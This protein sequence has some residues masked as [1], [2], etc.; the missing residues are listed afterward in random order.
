MKLTQKRIFEI[1]TFIRSKLDSRG[2]AIP[3]PDEASIAAEICNEINIIADESVRDIA[4]Y[5]LKQ[6]KSKKGKSDS[7][8]VAIDSCNFTSSRPEPPVKKRKSLDELT[9]RKQISRRVQLVFD[10]LKQYAEE[11]DIE[12]HRILGLLLTFSRQKAVSDIGESLW[13]NKTVNNPKQVPVDTALTIYNDCSLGRLTYTNMRKIAAASS[14]KV[15]PPWHHLRGKQKTITPAIHMLPNPYVGV[16][17]DLKDA[18]EM[19]VR[20]ILESQ[21]VN[22]KEIPGHAVEME[23]K[24]GFDGN[25]GNSIYNQVN[26]ESTNNIIMTMFCPLSLQDKSGGQLFS[27]SCPNSPMTQRPLC[28]QMGKETVDNLRS[29]EM[30]NEDI[31]VLANEGIQIVIED[32][33]RLQVVSKI[34]GYM[35]D[36]KAAKLYTGLGGSYCDLCCFSKEQCLDRNV[37][38]HGFNI[39]RDI[40]DIMTIF[41]ELVNENGTIITARNDYETR[42]GLTTK[43][44]TTNQ[45]LSEQVLHALL[46][47]FDHWMKTVVHVKAGVFDWSE[48]PTSWNQPFL[49]RAK[50]DIQDTIY[51]NIHGTKWDFP[52]TSGKGGTTTTGNVARDLLHNSSNREIILSGVSDEHSE[53]LSVYGRHLSVI[54][55]ILCSSRCV[56]VEQYKS[57]CTE[58]YLHLLDKFPRVHNKHLRGPWI[59]ITPS[60]HKLL[61][62]SWELILNNNSEGLL[63]LDE[64]GLEGCNKILRRIRTN[65]SRKTSQ[66]NNLSDTIARMWVGSDTVVQCERIKAM[67]FCKLCNAAGHG[68]RYC[69]RQNI[70]DSVLS[71]DEHLF[72]ILTVKDV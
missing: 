56:R 53:I 54:L 37:V 22:P 36:G 7:E 48:S 62:H 57:F 1:I 30:Y 25:G 46:R 42:G 70:K 65:L 66:H 50:K 34:V 47:N 44:I 23:I 18:V 9:S 20:R 67:P 26:N 49:N 43:P 31:S 10:Q 35:L 58:L 39:T 13:N 15:F 14:F 68:T 40:D 32:D 45:V 71:L 16:Y 61:A 3:Y 52:D 33:L 69:P 4:R 24:L 2:I 21:N 28:L 27:Q 64:S 6:Y 17:I 19:T 55:R 60:L 11:E 38:A 29:L 41:N 72:D 12:V 5:Q 51:N 63:R 59:S 8:Q